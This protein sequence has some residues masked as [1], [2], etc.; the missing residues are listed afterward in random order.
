M[1]PNSDE[2]TILKFWIEQVNKSHNGIGLAVWYDEHN[3]SDMKDGVKHRDILAR[4][5]LE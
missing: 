5:S 1:L 4:Q 2:S 3:K